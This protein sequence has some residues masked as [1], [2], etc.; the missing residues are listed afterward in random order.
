MI[1]NKQDFYKGIFLRIN[2]TT[3]PNMLLDNIFQ[4][5]ASRGYRGI[6][7]EHEYKAY[8][9]LVRFNRAF[10]YPLY[11][12]IKY[13]QD[14]LKTNISNT[15]SF[16]RKEMKDNNILILGTFDLDP[17]SK[18]KLLTAVFKT[19]INN[20]LYYGGK[21]FIEGK[22]GKKNEKYIDFIIGFNAFSYGL[23]L[24]QANQLKQE[25]YF[26]TLEKLCVKSIFLEE[27]DLSI[28]ID[29]R[30]ME[31]DFICDNKKYYITSQ[32]I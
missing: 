20:N 13:I 26:S 18:L 32:N 11:Y 12:R 3:E 29:V 31:L 1:I 30:N 5:F 27:Y 25:Y 28:A 21:D 19:I 23:F 24:E 10:L 4:A 8:D 9:A 2:K 7:I 15:V 17:K 14:A 16:L 6:I 22:R